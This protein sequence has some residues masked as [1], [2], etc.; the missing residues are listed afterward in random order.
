[1][2][3]HVQRSAYRVPT[4]TT[5]PSTDEDKGLLDTAVV[6]DNVSIW[7]KIEDQVHSLHRSLG[8][9]ESGALSLSRSPANHDHEQMRQ[10]AARCIISL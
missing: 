7:Q 5:N 2:L 1:M 6:A 9:E 3:Q 4:G 8:E 10:A